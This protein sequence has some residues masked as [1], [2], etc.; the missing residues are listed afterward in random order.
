MAQTRTLAGRV[1]DRASGEGLPGVTVLLRG[2]TTGISTNSDGSFTLTVPNDGGTLVFSSIGY[3]TIE[4]AIGGENQLAIALVADAKQLSEVVTAFGIERQAKSLTNSVQQVDGAAVTRAGQPNV[5]NALQGKV[6][7]VVVRQSSGMPGASSQIT[8]RGSRSF[9]GNNQPL[10]VVDGLPIESN[11]VDDAAFTGGVGQPDASS[12]ALDLNPNDIESISVLKGGAASALYGLRAAN[13]VV[14]ITTKKGRG[15]RKPKLSYSSDVQ[16]DKVSVLPDL[17]ST[18]AQGS[19]GAFNPNTSASWGPKLSALDPALKNNGGSNVVPGKVFDNVEPYFRTGH[20][21]TNAVDLS[22]GGEYGNFA[23]GLGYTNQLGI[24]PTTGLR[25][26]N[27]K[28]AGNF[29]LSPKIRLGASVNDSQV[30]VDKIPGGSNLSNPL[31]TTYYAPR[32]YGMW[33]IPFEDPGNPNLQI[34]YRAAIDN[35]RWALKHNAFSERTNRTFGSFNFS[36]R[37]LESLTLA[38]RVGLDYFITNGQGFYDL[39][40]GFTGGRTA[41][42]SGGQVRNYTTDQNQVNSNVS[43]TFDKTSPRAST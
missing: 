26:Y 31:F 1:T 35:P 42:P 5:T 8:I 9:T 7:G 18:Y 15:E 10:Y 13:G 23:V 19:G 3:T 16:L 12:R 43:L 17:Q 21:A 32:S 27:G 25:R 36:Y 38:Y 11:P 41:I 14:V 39:G 37:P 4:R 20:T 34:N 2:T 6:A 29:V 30:D 40:S 33:G 22:G 28:V 24:I